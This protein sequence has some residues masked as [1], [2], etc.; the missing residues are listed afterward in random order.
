[1]EVDGCPGRGDNGLD[2]GC[3][4]AKG[5][6]LTDKNDAVAADGAMLLGMPQWSYG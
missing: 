2:S 6:R 3:H 4:R 1:M 5:A